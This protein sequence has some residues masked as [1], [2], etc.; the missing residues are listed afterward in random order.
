MSIRS[1]IPA[2]AFVF[3]AAL[4][5]LFGAFWSPWAAGVI[6][7]LGNCIYR[8]R[9][10]TP[11]RRLSLMGDGCFPGTRNVAGRRHR[12]GRTE[13]HARSPADSTALRR[14]IADLDRPQPCQFQALQLCSRRIG[15]ALAF[16]CPR[17]GLLVCESRCWASEFLRCRL[18]VQNEVPIF[19]PEGRWWD[20]QFGAAVFTERASIVMPS[21][22]NATCGPAVAAAVLNAEIVGII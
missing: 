10:R 16:Q 9:A 12:A 19:P 6:A 3:L 21:L 14:R 13:N 5:E 7:L 20:K 4:C 1:L 15:S 17:C 18:C 2:F 8:S 22:A 11:I